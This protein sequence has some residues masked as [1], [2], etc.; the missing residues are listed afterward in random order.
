MKL[1]GKK[2][3]YIKFKGTEK[4]KNVNKT[5]VHILNRAITHSS[6]TESRLGFDN[7]LFFG[8]KRKWEFTEIGMHAGCMCVASVTAFSVR[9]VV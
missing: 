1:N 8:L 6:M 2:L 4:E 7:N 5:E 9:P 3:I